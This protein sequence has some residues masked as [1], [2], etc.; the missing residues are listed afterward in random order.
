MQ[1]DFL[2]TLLNILKLEGPYNNLENIFRNSFYT[3]PI[4]V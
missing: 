1:L 4:L 3:Y 2:L